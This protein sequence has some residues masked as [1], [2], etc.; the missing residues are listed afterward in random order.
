[1]SVWNNR[2]V[3]RTYTHPDG[4][5]EA[6]YQIHEAWYDKV[7]VKADSIT[8]DA[9]AAIGESLEELREDLER[10][11]RAVNFAIENSDAVLTHEDF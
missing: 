8:M 3:R 2:V 5:T 4:S 1:M 6:T 9:V 11:L 10:R 7:D